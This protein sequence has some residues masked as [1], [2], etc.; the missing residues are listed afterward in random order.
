MLAIFDML[1]EVRHHLAEIY[2]TYIVSMC[3][4]STTCSPSPCSAASVHGRA[5]P[6]RAS[7]VDLVPL[8]ETIKELSQAGPLLDE[9]LFR[10]GL[11][12]Q[13]GDRGDLQVVLGYQARTA[14]PDHHLAVADPP[15]AARSSGRRSSAG[16]RLRLFLSQDGSL[17]RASD[18]QQAV[19]VTPFGTLTPT[20]KLTSRTI[21]GILAAA[22][23][24]DNLEYLLASFE[25]LDA[26]LL[27]ARSGSA[28]RWTGSTSD[29]PRRRPCPCRISA[30]RRRP[31]CQLL[32]RRDRRRLQPLD[33]LAGRSKRPAS[34]PTLDDLPA[35]SRGF[36]GRRRRGRSSARSVRAAGARRADGSA[37]ASS[38]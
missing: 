6:A 20:M 18:Q 35:N 14:R 19:I 24:H 13:V 21:F 28:R 36:F 3:Q 26:T 33:R 16:M 10:A 12:R 30:S 11:R 29:R 32:L 4:A 1:H 2:S 25:P 27:H 15:G 37:G 34:A 9:L 22:L 5:G 17:S 8:F 7:S 23:R 38:R 31:G